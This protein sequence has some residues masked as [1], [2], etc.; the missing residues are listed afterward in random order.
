MFMM[1]EQLPK[2]VSHNAAPAE[3]TGDLLDEIHAAERE[4]EFLD[5]LVLD[6]FPADEDQ[7]RKTW[8]EVPRTVRAAIRRL[9]TMLNHKPK[10]VMV[11][12]MKG[13]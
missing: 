8:L 1:Q 11:Q 5:P 12:I 10:E 6:G 13:A 7:R 9:H 4:Q 3:P 2:S